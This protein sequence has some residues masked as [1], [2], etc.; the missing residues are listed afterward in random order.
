[1]GDILAAVS[2]F[3]GFR[4]PEPGFLNR[5]SQVRFLQPTLEPELEAKLVACLREIVALS[6][7]KRAELRSQLDT[8]PFDE[9]EYPLLTAALAGTTAP[10]N[11]KCCKTCRSGKACGD[12]CISKSKTCRAGPGCACNG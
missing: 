9:S 11:G 3:E 1:M 4:D 7:S 5:R 12:S 10:L 6:A 2:C 8:I